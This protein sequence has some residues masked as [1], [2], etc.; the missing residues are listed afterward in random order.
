ME[1]T[2]LQAE[3]RSTSGKG[4]ARRLRATGRIPAVVYGAGGEAKS[5]SVSPDALKTAVGGEFGLNT[6]LDLDVDGAATRVMLADY[7][8]HP[9]SREVLHADFLAIKDDAKLKI[10]VPLEFTGK[11]KGAVM[12]GRL[13]QVYRKVPVRCLPAHIPA[14]ISHDVTELMIDDTVRVRDL[15]L[16]AGVEMVYPELQTLGGLY[17]ARQRVEETTEAEAGEASTEEGEEKAES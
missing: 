2:K 8:M 17:G 9:L 12:G 5:L 7:Q 11:P 4:N 15:K 16:P 14:K 3:S 6:L 13:R 10:E 1:T